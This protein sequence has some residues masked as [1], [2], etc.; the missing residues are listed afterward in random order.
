VETLEHGAALLRLGCH[1]AQGF[2]IA[3]P[4]PAEQLFDWLARWRQDAAW[5]RIAPPS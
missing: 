4:M 3:R 2:G 5:T 1:L